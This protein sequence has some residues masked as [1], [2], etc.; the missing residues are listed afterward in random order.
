MTSLVTSV[1]R[2][3]TYVAMV[4][5]FV[6]TLH[7]AGSVALRLATNRDIPLTLE[8]TAD[9]YMVALTFIP[10]AM[11]DLAQRHIRAEFLAALLPNAVQYVLG[12][13]IRL[14][15]L[16]YLALLT[17][18]STL[19]AIGRTQA[20]DAKITIIGSFPT[21]PARWIVPF[22][23]AVACL[24]ALVLLVR[25][26]RGRDDDVTDIADQDNDNA[27]GEAV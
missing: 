5:M 18:R 16:G 11:I 17:W 6:M 21:W 9:Y 23:L 10:L 1:S 14:A 26:L 20:G 24:A 12:I 13:L 7:V 2:G 27:G 15:M 22:G 3:L 25:A 8:I 19:N 4:I